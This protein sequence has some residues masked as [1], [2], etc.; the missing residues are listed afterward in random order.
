MKEKI[1]SFDFD[2]VLTSLK[3]VE[4]FRL[5]RKNNE[6]IVII[7][8]RDNTKEN[9]KEVCE[10]SGLEKNKIFLCGGFMNKLKEIKKLIDNNPDKDII[11]IDDDVSVKDFF[12]NFDFDN[13]EI[14]IVK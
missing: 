2:G 4:S 11:H 13:L 7:S 5:R 14:Q 8:S 6:D 12:N 10:T 3:Y 9:M 1:I